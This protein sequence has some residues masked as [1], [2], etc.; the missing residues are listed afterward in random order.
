VTNDKPRDYVLR[1][2]PQP[3]SR[4]NEG[5]KVALT[6]SDGPA[7]TPVPDVTDQP[8]AQATRTLARAG[9]NVVV[10]REPSDTIVSGHATRTSPPAS[11]LALAQSN[12]TLYISSG[13]AQVT[14]PDVSGDSES[15]ATFALSNAGLRTDVT[16]Q[17]SSSQSPGT[18]LSQDP[19][20]GTMVAKGA[21]VTIVVAKA[22]SQVTV[23]GVVG[24][25][26]DAATSRLQ[27]AGF[28][29][30]PQQRKVT[31]SAQDGIVLAQ[32][33]PGGSKASNGATVT[34]VVGK[35]ATPTPPTLPAPV[36]QGQ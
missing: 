17:E 9:F 22:P 1:E 11:S 18:V 30:S 36:S 14:V 16:E 28:N 3:G 12:V 6:V 2:D 31:D 7:Q 27:G 4:V 26:Q 32:R 10:Q 24:Q 15:A 20:A 29:V 21:T 19:A 5:E 33:P 8:Q 23:P 35:L 13:V 34:I 25:K